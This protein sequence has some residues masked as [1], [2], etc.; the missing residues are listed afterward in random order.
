[1]SL[2]TRNCLFP[3]PFLLGT[4]FVNSSVPL[5][6]LQLY[7]NGTFEGTTNYSNKFTNYAIG[8]KSSPN[9]PVMPI[10][11]GKSY[12]VTFVATFQDGSVSNA[13]TVVVAYS[14]TTAT[15]Q[16]VSSAQEEFDFDHI[17][18]NFR[19]GNFTI[20]M[21]YNG[22]DYEP[23]SVSGTMT[24]Y[25]GFV[26]AFNV[27]TPDGVTKNVLFP[28]LPTDPCVSDENYSCIPKNQW[29]LPNP[30]NV[31]LSYGTNFAN[32]YIVWIL[33]STNLYVSF[34]QFEYV[35]VAGPTPALYVPGSCPTVNETYPNMMTPWSAPTSNKAVYITN[36]TVYWL[37][38]ASDLDGNV[39]QPS[40]D[41]SLRAGQVLFYDVWWSAER[42]DYKID[43]VYTNTS[44]FAVLGV[45]SNGRMVSLSQPVIEG[46][47]F[48]FEVLLQLPTNSSYMGPVNIY[49][50]TGQKTPGCENCNGTA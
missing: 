20:E 12:D 14:T 2:C 26:W 24:Q 32:L 45:C 18:Y 3:S 29:I 50:Q 22:T 1:M 23:P 5:Q 13:S 6:T 40:Q 49:I 41:L 25:L 38:P 19:V 35:P 43:S 9:N 42:F 11:S 48:G 10:V 4:V 16:P 17:L 47:N 7:I 31:T 21:V 46:T 33:N 8:Y 34:I 36:L 15:T 39:T 37:G 44:G 27:T 28:W 30:E